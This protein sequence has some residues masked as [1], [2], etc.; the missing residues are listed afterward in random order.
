MILIIKN[1]VVFFVVTQLEYQKMSYQIKE[2]LG[3][4]ENGTCN[5]YS[6]GSWT[7]YSDNK[8]LVGSLLF[9]PNGKN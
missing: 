4:R 9:A 7:I 8:Y 1:G 5:G 6:S 2:R 3:T